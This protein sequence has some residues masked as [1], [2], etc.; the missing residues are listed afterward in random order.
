MQWR[1]AIYRWC[2]L[3]NHGQ[4]EAAVEQGQGIAPIERYSRKDWLHFP[5]Y[6]DQIARDPELSR[7]VLQPE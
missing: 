5:F 6:E 2:I 1:T 4:D 3:A 7:I